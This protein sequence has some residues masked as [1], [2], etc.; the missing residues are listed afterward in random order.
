M[1]QINIP[2]FGTVSAALYN[3]TNLIPFLLATKGADGQ[4]SDGSL[5]SIFVENPNSFFMQSGKS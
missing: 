1:G 2:S 5:S 3:G 4:T